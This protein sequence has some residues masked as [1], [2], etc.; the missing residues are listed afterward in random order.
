MG[1]G[2]GTV[3]FDDYKVT[4]RKQIAEGGF[5]YV[6]L[7]EDEKGHKFA[8]KRVIVPLDD[9]ERNNVARSEQVV[10]S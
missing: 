4:H 10:L 3:V 7:V 6:S 8:M 9:T 1:N 2:H 5:G